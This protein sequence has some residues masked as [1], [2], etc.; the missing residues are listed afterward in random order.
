[1]HQLHV[2]PALKDN[3]IW[4]L[5]NKKKQVVII[6]PGEASPVI[7]CLKKHLLF[8]LAILLTHHH[9]DHVKGVAELQA[10]YPD[11][12]IYGPSEINLQIN[13]LDNI[14]KISIGDFQFDII[15]V[16]SH[17]LG[18]LAYYSQPY[19]FCGDTLF[20]AGCGKVFTG[21]YEQM[22][23]SLKKIKQLPDETFICAGHEYTL[24]NLDF[25]QMM[26]PHDQIIHEY[27]NVICKKK[28]TLPS[29]LT[30]E[31]QINLFLR[32]DEK[33]LQNKFNCNNELD[34]FVFLRSQK[35]IF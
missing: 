19:L 31:K 3:Y 32:C 1:M 25:A 6:D 8:P 2:I 12:E 7:S 20:S 5:E 33:S 10:C 22:L 27:Y 26:V 24:A 21:M 18:H 11:V 14:G 15:S 30:K 29:I 34:L 35:D 13:H 4:L 16:P 23:S 9:I 28:I 17:T